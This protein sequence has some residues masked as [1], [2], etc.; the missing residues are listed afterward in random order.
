MATKAPEVKPHASTFIVR[1]PSQ[2]MIPKAIISG[3]YGPRGERLRHQVH[4][5]ALHMPQESIDLIRNV[6]AQTGVT[7]PQKFSLP[8]LDTVVRPSVDPN[9]EKITVTDVGLEQ[10]RVLRQPEQP[11]RMDPLTMQMFPGS[12]AIYET[13]TR[14]TAVNRVIDRSISA[15]NNPAG[16]NPATER[17][18]GG[19]GEDG[20]AM[21]TSDS[22]AVPP[23][24]EA[25]PEQPQSQSKS[26]QDAAAPAPTSQSA[27]APA[28]T[29]SSEQPT[30]SSASQPAPAAPV[31]VPSNTTS[32]SP[33][34]AATEPTKNTEEAK[35]KSANSSSTDEPT[36]KSLSKVP[37]SQWEQHK[38]GA[39][40]ETVS[41]PD[42]LTGK[43]A[44]Y[45]KEKI[46]DIERN[47][48][49]EWFNASSTHR[50][51]E[52]YL[53][54]RNKVIEMADKLANRNLTTSMIRRSIVGDAGS[55]HRLHSFLVNWGFVNED[56]INDS[57]PTP[58]SLRG[59]LSG[60]KRFNEELQAE[61]VQVVVEQSKRCK[62]DQDDVMTDENE[63]PILPVVPIDW[64]EVS[65]KIGHGISA[66][67]CEQE[68][69]KLPLYDGL[70]SSS[71]LPEAAEEGDSS[72]SKGYTQDVASTKKKI[73]QELVDESSPEVV[74][75][76]TQAALEATEGDL[77][78][79]QKAGLIGLVASQAVKKAR[80]KEE[81]VS[82]LLNELVNQ[83]MQ[84]LENRLALMDDMEGML[85][86]ER[87][88]LEL[89]RRDL[90]TARCRHWF[91]GP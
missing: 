14:P 48:L 7:A 65:A 24:P 78:K 47:M 64:D 13:V 91:M 45:D 68:F 75:K 74:S 36:L 71:T 18:R 41:S 5:G 33:A 6:A 53:T 12:P 31:T 8:G 9:V 50:T 30:P 90:Y 52:S 72:E 73:F 37:P 84:K 19:G 63:T 38:A 79:A 54:T 35:L 87:V 25:A 55:L 28:P 59:G 49:P 17:I 2:G 40:D 16:A 29:Q 27:P 4:D 66:K 51:P 56:A 23:A 15:N 70:P 42:Q 11:P 82:S 88:A 81:A 83:R 46:S 80:S 85:E 20:D 10:V 86:A 3:L 61:L 57:C 69:L 89:E 58:M 22:P 67:E 60:K 26:A 1:D 62:K 43:P 77:V 32:E 21:D 39:N 44:W 76:V 34:S